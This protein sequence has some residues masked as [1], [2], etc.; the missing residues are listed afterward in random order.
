MYYDASSVKGGLTILAIK[1]NS[2]PME[3]FASPSGFGK[4]PLPREDKW[5]SPLTPQFSGLGF[6]ASN[7]LSIRY[8]T[9]PDWFLILLAGSFSA[10]SLP[11]FSLRTLLLAMTFLAIAMGMIIWA[12]K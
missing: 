4:V 5:P 10:A 6:V 12:S 9:V 1:E 8:V 11:R 7:E 2:S 3:Q